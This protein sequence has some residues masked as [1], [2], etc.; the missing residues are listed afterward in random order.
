MHQTSFLDH[1]IMAQTP[2]KF[3]RQIFERAT[4]AIGVPSSLND[5][6]GG[7][8]A[9]SEE[10]QGAV[11]EE[12]TWLFVPAAGR[13]C[14]LAAGLSDR[15]GRGNLIPASYWLLCRV[16][17]VGRRTIVQRVFRVLTA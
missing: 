8:Q 14:R 13:S 3:P 5:G 10:D 1:P 16:A 9:G 15:P 17:F 11:A 2:A 12:G 6:G 7:H 4:P